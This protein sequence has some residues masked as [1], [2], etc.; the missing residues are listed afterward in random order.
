ML[1]LMLVDS[2]YMSL[3]TLEFTQVAGFAALGLGV[4]M[5]ILWPLFALFT[6][7]GAWLAA[8]YRWARQKRGWALCGAL[9]GGCLLAGFA[10]AQSEPLP[11]PAYA[12]FGA[13]C[14]LGAGL[15]CY[16][17]IGVGEGLLV[18]SH[19]TCA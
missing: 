13:L 18:D 16:R 2:P 9:I 19:E 7:L 17:W 15:L 1:V 10:A 14:G 3:Q 4:G 12:F 8:R 11:L 6:A 5:I